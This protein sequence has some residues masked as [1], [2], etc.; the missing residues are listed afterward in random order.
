M[1]QK[2][3]RPLIR[4]VF[5]LAASLALF[6]PALSGED[7]KPKEAAGPLPKGVLARINGQPITQEDYLRYLFHSAGLQHLQ[8]YIDK[9]LVQEEARRLGVEIPSAAADKETEADLQRAL[10]FFHNNRDA[11]IAYLKSRGIDY[12]EHKERTRQRI[13]DRITLDQC[14]L[15][16]RGIGPEDVK[17]KFVELYGK[18]GISLFFRSILIA[19][20]SLPG[21]LESEERRKKAEAVLEEAHATSHFEAVAKARSEDAAT[22]DLGGLLPLY[23]KKVFGEEFDKAAEQLK[24]VGDLS[25]VFHTSEGWQ[26]IQLADRRETRLEDVYQPILNQL[27]NQAP[28]APEREQFLKALRAKARIERAAPPENK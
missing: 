8:D 3:L 12:E 6:N 10:V 11:H 5:R 1:H 19:D 27:K 22:K 25:D 24:R 26:F 13:L 15:K 17:R 23:F 16:S 21:S 18:D 4:W 28:A 9:Q 14:V 20:T 7:S 2:L